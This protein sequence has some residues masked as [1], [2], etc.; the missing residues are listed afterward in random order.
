MSKGQYPAMFDSHAA[1]LGHS[2]TAGTAETRR[3]IV[4]D[5]GAWLVDLIDTSTDYA[6]KVDEANGSTTYIGEADIASDGT[7]AVWRIRRVIEDTAA[8]TISTITWCDGDSKF[9]NIWDNRGTLS[10]S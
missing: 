3:A 6:T 8:G 2:G 4:T 9:N 10:Y 1:L 5:K 7:S